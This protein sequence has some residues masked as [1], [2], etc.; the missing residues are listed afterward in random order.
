MFKNS[1]YLL[2]KKVKGMYLKIVVKLYL[3]IY[4][5]NLNV[6]VFLKVSGVFIYIGY[7]FLNYFRK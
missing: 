5:V 4:I 1:R 3:Y 7:N 6:K 2:I